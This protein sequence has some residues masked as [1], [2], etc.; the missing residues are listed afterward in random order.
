MGK[1]KTAAE[2][3]KVAREK[4][5]NDDMTGIDD[6]PVLRKILGYSEGLYEVQIEV[7]RE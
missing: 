5:F 3:V 1:K 6:R 7:W 4:R 2:R